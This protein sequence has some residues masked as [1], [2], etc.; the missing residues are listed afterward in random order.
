MAPRYVCFHPH[1]ACVIW[2]WFPTA[3]LFLSLSPLCLSVS[4]PLSLFVCVRTRVCL[5]HRA[6]LSNLGRLA[7][8]A[9]KT[10]RQLAQ[11]CSLL[12]STSGCQETAERC[13]GGGHAQAV[14]SVI[15]TLDRAAMQLLPFDQG[16]PICRSLV[17]GKQP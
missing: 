1:W 16:S 2:L 13:V 10:N 12:F 8:S 3:F 6:A 14:H 9:L 11:H 4:L 15:T 7:G 5:C 17:C